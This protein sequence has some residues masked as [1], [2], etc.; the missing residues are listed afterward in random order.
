MERPVTVSRVRL[1]AQ[2]R[3]AESRAVAEAT[4]VPATPA[5]G[6]V[7]DAT[8]V[9][10]GG[11]G[12]A[13]GGGGADGGGAGA[14]HTSSSCAIGG[15]FG[16]RAFPSAV[17]S[18]DHHENASTT[19]ESFSVYGTCRLPVS[20]ICVAPARNGTPST[21]TD[22]WT[23]FV[24]DL[25]AVQVKSA[26]LQDTSAAGRCASAEAGKTSATRVS[27]AAA[28]SFPATELDEDLRT[29]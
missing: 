8:G 26:P 24:P 3:C 19:C 15:D 1:V 22:Q 12:A 9:A 6:G 23:V 4:R 18:L 29:T 11:A 17:S 7:G 20:P 10:A 16:D 5:D 2:R 27:A 25:N 28:A 14:G 13:G 21:V